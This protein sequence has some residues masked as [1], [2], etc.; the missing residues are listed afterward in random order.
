MENSLTRSTTLI[1]LAFLVV[2]TTASF[3]L[4]SQQV[5]AQTNATSSAAT[6]TTTNQTYTAA[7]VPEAEEGQEAGAAEEGGGEN[8]FVSQ[9]IPLTGQLTSGDYILLMDFTPFK[10]S[11]EGHSHIAMKVPC[12]ESGGPEITIVTGVAPNLTTLDIGSAINNG[13]LN[14]NSLDLSNEGTSCLYHAAIP[15]NIT[16]IAMVNT[17]GETL[18]FDEGGFSVT[19]SAHAI[20]GEHEEEGSDHQHS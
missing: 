1:I 16:D 17:S 12:N 7:T 5:D 9:H 11:P 15:G 2:T 3:S 13:T 19:V 18:N 4:L 20:V 8:L 6:A 10:I 14:G